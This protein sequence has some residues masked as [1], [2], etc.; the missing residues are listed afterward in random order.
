M[1]CEEKSDDEQ[2]NDEIRDFFSNYYTSDFGDLQKNVI[3]SDIEMEDAQDKY[4]DTITSADLKQLMDFHLIVVRNYTKT[5]W[6]NPAKDKH[7][8]YNFVASL[9][10]KYQIFGPILQKIV[11]GVNC[12]MDAELLGSLNVLVA[13]TQRYGQVDDVGK[14]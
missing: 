14:W 12:L 7:I 6:L 1:K 3:S 4:K 10:E 13:V 11:N 9:V 2:T 5:E 8:N